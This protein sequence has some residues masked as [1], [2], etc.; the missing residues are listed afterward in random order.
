MVVGDVVYGLPVVVVLD[1]DCEGSRQGG[2]GGG[3]LVVFL[4]MTHGDVFVECAVEDERYGVD[5]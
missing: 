5:V 1:F 3:E 4:V 2:R